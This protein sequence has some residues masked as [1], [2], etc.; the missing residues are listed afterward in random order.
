MTGTARGAGGTTIP[1]G[2]SLSDANPSDYVGA[3]LV[4][5]PGFIGYFSGYRLLRSKLEE[6]GESG[7]FLAAVGESLLLLARI[8]L[9]KDKITADP[10]DITIA[11]ALKNEGAKIG[12]AH[13]ALDGNILTAS[14]QAPPRDV[15]SQILGQLLVLG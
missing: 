9:L 2:T 4:G 14:N 13:I 7:K 15:A 8:G 11:S 1:V 10:A 5:G 6:M 3:I 12:T